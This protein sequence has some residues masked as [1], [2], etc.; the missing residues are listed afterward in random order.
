MS[1]QDSSQAT[2]ILLCCNIT[3]HVQNL[4]FSLF[5]LPFKLKKDFCPL[6]WNLAAVVVT[7]ENRF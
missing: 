7:E 6:E 2:Y 5:V 4:A 3:H 1:L